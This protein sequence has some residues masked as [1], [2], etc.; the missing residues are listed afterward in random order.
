MIWTDL[1]F[2]KYV[3]KSLPQLVLV[4]P[5]WFFWAMDNDVFKGSLKVQAAELSKRA[6][7]IKIPDTETPG[8]A[9]EYIIHPG[10]GKLGDVRVVPKGRPAHEGASPT[11]RKPYFDLSM[12]RQISPYDKTG[13]KLIVRA[14]KKHV[15]GSEA[16]KITRERAEKFFSDAKYFD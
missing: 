6:T 7:R 9:V 4:D 5:D 13:G 10:V 2:G 1:S 14:V 12:A 3:G 11:R 8:S 16:A 15:F